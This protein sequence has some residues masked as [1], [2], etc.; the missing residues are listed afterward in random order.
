ML[1]CTLKLNKESQNM[2]GLAQETSFFALAYLHRLLRLVK[3][4]GK[5]FTG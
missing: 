3:G 1:P 4:A 5:F 2:P